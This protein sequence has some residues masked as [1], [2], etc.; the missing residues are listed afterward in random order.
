MIYIE[1]ADASNRVATRSTLMVASPGPFK[2]LHIVQPTFNLSDFG[3]HESSATPCDVNIFTITLSSNIPV[4]TGMVVTIAGLGHTATP[5]NELRTL[6]ASRSFTSGFAENFTSGFVYSKDSWAMV[7]RLTTEGEGSLAF[8]DEEKLTDSYKHRQQLQA[9]L[10]CQ[11]HETNCAGPLLNCEST[12]AHRG[13]PMG[14]PGHTKE[15]Y[16]AAI[17]M[18]ACKLSCEAVFN[19]DG[20]LYCRQDQCDLHYTTDIFSNPDNECLAKKCSTPPSTF[21]SS[22]QCCTSDFT[23]AE[24]DR[25]CVTLE[26]TIQASP[27]NSENNLSLSKWTTTQYMNTSICHKIMSHVDFINLAVS[28]NKTMVTELLDAETVAG[29]TGKAATAERLILDYTNSAHTI[30]ASDVYVQSSHKEH[31]AAWLAGLK[32]V[33]AVLRVTESA[34]AILD[35]DELSSLNPPL[36]FMAAHLDALLSSPTGVQYGNELVETPMAKHAKKHKMTIWALGYTAE[37]LA[38]S[39]SSYLRKDADSLLLLHALLKGTADAVFTD[40]TEKV[41]HYEN[42]VTARTSS[43]NLDGNSTPAEWVIGSVDRM[44]KIPIAGGVLQDT[45][46]ELTFTLEVKLR[47]P[48]FSCVLFFPCAAAWRVLTCLLTRRTLPRNRLVTQRPSLLA[49]VRYVYISA[50]VCACAAGFLRATTC[51]Q[52]A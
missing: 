18:G 40:W 31:V 32:Y 2:P 8:S 9:D 27:A 4:P 5:M 11:M 7:T 38:P 48:F 43:V 29:V 14:Y 41:S 17:T 47:L 22:A 21:G 51:M 12:I 35:L 39:T 42:C 37:R 19:A 33:N 24:L 16:E 45:Q 49:C 15:G 25:L 20:D 23:A 6:P 34:Q 13:A 36:K 28:H 52:T 10:Q 26:M 50:C 30:S 44:L 46:F 1:G 3:W